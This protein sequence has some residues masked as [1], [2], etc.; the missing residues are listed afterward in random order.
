MTD[1]TVRTETHYY[2]ADE[3][4]A[5][6]AFYNGKTCVVSGDGPAHMLDAALGISNI[7]VKQAVLLSL[8]Q[9]LK[10]GLLAS[11]D[12]RPASSSRST[13]KARCRGSGKCYTM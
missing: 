10:I 2:P 8:T 13:S 7:R 11:M 6:R 3:I 9:I 4:N 12:V 5:M 1:P